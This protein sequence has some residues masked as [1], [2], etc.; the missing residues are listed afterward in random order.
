M[1]DKNGQILIILILAGMVLGVIAV[2]IFGAGIAPVKFLGDIFL[3]ALK[4]IVIPLLF[5][6]MVVGISNLGDVRKLGRTGAKTLLYFL[7]TS[8]FSVIIGILL[9]NIFRPG[10]G[11]EPFATGEAPEQINYNVFQWIT[12]Q[13]PANIIQAAAQTEVLPIIVF[14]LFFGAVLTTIGNKGKPVIA[15]FEGVNEAIMKIVHVIMWFAPIG[16]FGLVAGQLAER[17]GLSEFSTVVS[18]LGKY[19]L[20]VIVGLLIH[21][22]VVLPLI[23]KFIA[24]RNPIEYFVGVSQAIMTAF[25]TAS[26]SAT[27]PVTLESVEENNNVD[28]RAASFVLP[29]GATINMDGTALYEAVAA[30]FI[31]QAYGVPL[32]IFAQITIFLTAILASV[33]AAGIPQ[34]GLVTMVLVLSAVGLPLEG[35]GLI[36]AI[37][38]FLDRCRTA[39]NVWGDSIGAA[40]IASTAEISIVQRKPRRQA[41]PRDSRRDTRYK[42]P[43]SRKQ[44]SRGERSR[45]SGGRS[46]GAKVQ[47]R[48]L[49]STDEGGRR[50]DRRDRR[51]D[52]RRKRWDRRQEPR[53]QRNPARRQEDRD[54]RSREAEK[55]SAR[56][57]SKGAQDMPRFPATVL[58]DLG[59]E[60]D[61]QP[62]EPQLSEVAEEEV[63][64]KSSSEEQPTKAESPREST[65]GVA[66]GD[67]DAKSGAEYGRRPRHIGPR[68]ERQEKQET[69]VRSDREAKDS[70]IQ[71]RRFGDIESDQ[72]YGSNEQPAGGSGADESR[73]EEVEE[74]ETPPA[75]TKQVEKDNEKPAAEE[76][77]EENGDEKAKEDE[78]MQWG[79]SKKRSGRS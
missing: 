51:E 24:G 26:S 17:G 6:S 77:G 72:E 25:A 20:V 76:A 35:I 16:I 4:M 15:F 54:T 45:T 53:D 67:K 37:D 23:L 41:P 73:P 71:S 2:G 29:L 79:R 32:S 49:N 65:E 38:W 63:E 69:T 57:D 36:L 22:V 31:A 75:S 28:E 52:T 62:A 12:N 61:T 55:P 3:N 9:V 19:S 70:P 18:A 66:T 48:P 46:R 10:S 74:K 56:E 13:I 39:V 68:G 78:N 5:A 44:S 60:A 30:I 58:T 1:F 40:V 34:A 64:K 27:L 11:F 42:G 8:A 50:T 43:R 33:G 14:A 47:M 59:K 21:A 7:V